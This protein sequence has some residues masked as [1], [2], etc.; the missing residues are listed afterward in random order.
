M[1]TPL[2][3]IGMV[4][5]SLCVIGTL[6]AGVYIRWKSD[7]KEDYELGGALVF[8]GIL[9]MPAI[10]IGILATFAGV[11]FLLNK[12]MIIGYKETVNK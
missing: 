8:C 7:N 9:V 5:F 2:E 4:Y 3:I 10:A 6:T 1:N 12:L 11:M